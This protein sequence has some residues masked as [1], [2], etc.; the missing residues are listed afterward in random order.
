MRT[1]REEGLD[2]IFNGETSVEEILKYT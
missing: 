1:L 2:A